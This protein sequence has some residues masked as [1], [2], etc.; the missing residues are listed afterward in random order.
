[1]N[2]LIDADALEKKVFERMKQ[3]FSLY[4]RYNICYC[5]EMAGEIKGQYIE[6][7]AVHDLIKKEK[8][9]DSVPV[10]HGH[11]EK[12][13]I[14]I[15]IRNNTTRTYYFKCNKC[16]STSWNRNNYCSHCGAKMDEVTE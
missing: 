16:S 15:E 7:R 2:R 6:A 11:W 3:H 9:I 1:M 13:P 4:E 10:V 5:N 14:P 8:T 12:T